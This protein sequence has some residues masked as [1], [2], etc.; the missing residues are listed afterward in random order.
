MLKPHIVFHSPV[1]N[2][3]ERK[4]WEHLLRI[5]PP[6][7]QARC[8]IGT[9]IPSSHLPRASSMEASQ[10]RL[11]DLSILDSV[12]RDGLKTISV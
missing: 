5:P 7:Q 1:L 3:G 2:S 11:S 9:T 8:L 10:A 6:G 4:A 12:V